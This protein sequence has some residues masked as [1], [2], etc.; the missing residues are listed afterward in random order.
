M[1]RYDIAVRRSAAKELEKSVAHQ[2]RDRIVEAIDAL[3]EDP[4]PHRCVKVRG[5]PAGTFRIR[6]GDYRIIY[7]VRDNNHMVIVARITRRSEDTYKN[8]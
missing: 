5:A 2:D 6:A 8:L 4:R 1:P 3:A 7:V